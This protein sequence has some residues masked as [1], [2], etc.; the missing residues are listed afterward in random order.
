MCVCVRVGVC[1]YKELRGWRLRQRER[2]RK[3]KGGEERHRLLRDD[4]LAS[5]THY[6]L[7]GGVSVLDYTAMLAF[8]L[9]AALLSPLPP[10][11]LLLCV[12]TT[13]RIPRY[14]IHGIRCTIYDCHPPSH[15]L[16]PLIIICHY[17]S[18]FI[19]DGF[20]YERD[21]MALTRRT[22]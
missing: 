22:T 16:P 13:L 9:P 19:S 18:L 20:L 17:L 12:Y 3:A 6:S 21:S 5:T 11:S 10:P 1:V 4:V 8:L 7:G 14:M 15:L 2:R